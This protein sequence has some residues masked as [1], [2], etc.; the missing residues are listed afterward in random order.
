MQNNLNLESVKKLTSDLETSQNQQQ[1]LQQ[2]IKSISQNVDD[3]TKLLEQSQK[4]V[5]I[6]TFIF[7][8][9]QYFV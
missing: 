9:F 6:Y 4:D 1:T 7:T 3:K 2:Q 8:N 5:I